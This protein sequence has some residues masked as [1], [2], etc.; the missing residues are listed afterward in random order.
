MDFDLGFPP[1]EPLRN[2][3]NGTHADLDKLPE[4]GVPVGKMCE[5][6]V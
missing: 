4:V 2:C 1:G 6:S 5:L 3:S